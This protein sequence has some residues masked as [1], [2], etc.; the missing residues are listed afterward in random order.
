MTA[1]QHGCPPAF[2]LIQAGLSP[3]LV[4]GTQNSMRWSEKSLLKL[5]MREK[6]INTVKTEAKA[7]LCRVPGEEGKGQ[8][9]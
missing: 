4:T 1:Q 5:N 9:C 7:A 3:L 2:L 8:E 6:K